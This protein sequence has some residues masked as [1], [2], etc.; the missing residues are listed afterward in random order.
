[1][2]HIDYAC[3]AICNEEIRYVYPDVRT[4]LDVCDGCRMTTGIGSVAELLDALRFHPLS[5]IMAIAD[6]YKPCEF[7]NIV[8]QRIYKATQKLKV[9]NV[10]GR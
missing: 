8:D 5:A 7:R 3:C 4:K 10:E 2:S 6:R 9:P 1:M